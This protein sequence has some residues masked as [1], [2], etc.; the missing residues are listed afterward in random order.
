MIN[1]RFPGLVGLIL[2]TFISQTIAATDGVQVLIKVT[3]ESI[4]GGPVPPPNPESIAGCT[5]SVATNYSPTATINDGSCTYTI[6]I[7]NV[8]NFSSLYLIAQN[9]V[10]L[11]WN[12]PDFPDF[13]A[14][15]VIRKLNTLPT[16]PTDG[17]LIYDGPTENTL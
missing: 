5:D 14:V 10:T 7:P 12:N 16:D 17:L 8:N 9:Q 4:S 1:L 6:T 13:A 11:T 3:D 15:R 2:L